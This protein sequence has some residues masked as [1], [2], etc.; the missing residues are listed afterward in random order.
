MHVARRSWGIVAV[1]LFLTIISTATA[2][3]S[4]GTGE[5]NDPYQIATAADLIALGETAEDYDKHFI[6]TADI[7]LDP[8][9]P[10]RKVFDKAV[11]ASDVNNVNWDFDG[12]PFTG[13]FD[14]MGH[15]ISHLTMKGVGYLGLFGQFGEWNGPGCAVR[16]LGVVAVNITGSGNF[17][18]DYV[19]GLVGYNGSGTLAQCYSTGTVS[20]TTENLAVGG[21]VGYNGSGTLAQCYSSVLV[22]GSAYDVG[23]LVGLNG[24]IVT[25]CYSTG[26]VSGTYEVGGLVGANYGTVT[27][28]YSTGAVSSS[29]NSVGGLVGSHS[30]RV[31]HSIWDVE[32]S[33]LSRSGGG[34]GLTTEEMMDSYVIGLKGF[35]NDPNWVLDAGHDYPRLAW[36]GTP[37]TIIPVPDIDWF[38]GH[39]TAEDPYR[40]NTADQF[41]SLGRESILCDRHFVLSADIDLDPNLPGGQVFTQAPIPLFVG[42]LDGCGH[43]ISHLRI[44]GNGYLGVFGCIESGAEVKNLGVVDV[45][46]AGSL[47]FV[48]SLAGYN[49]GGVSQCYSTGVVSGRSYVGGLVGSNWSGTV[50]RCSS[51]GAVNGSDHVGGLVGENR[52]GTITWCYS[53]VE[54]EGNAERRCVGG[55]VGGNSGRLDQCYST[56]VVN[57]SGEAVGGLV[58]YN[59]DS[60]TRCYSTG[61]VSGNEDVG[62]L[63]GNNGYAGSVIHCHSTGTVSGERHVG[64]LVGWNEG[65]VTHCYS[66]GA[67]IGNEDVGGLIGWPY[68]SRCQSMPPTF[69]DVGGLIGWPYSSLVTACFWDTQTSGQTTSAGGTGKTTAEMQRAKMFLDAGWYP[70]GQ[71]AVWTIDEGRDYPRLSW[72]DKPGERIQAICLSD[73]LAGRGTRDDP[74]LIFTPEDLNM[75]GLATCDLDK[76]FRLMADIDLSGF[77]GK[78]SRP[79]FNIIA[80]GEEVGYV[81]YYGYGRSWGSYCQGVPFTGVFDG[82]GHTVLNFTYTCTSTASVYIG[83]FGNVNDPNAQIKDLG[84]IEPNVIRSSVPIEPGGH[85]ACLVGCL[86][87]GTISG[88]YVRGGSVKGNYDYHVGGLVGSNGSCISWSGVKSGDGQVCRGG[89]ILNSYTS[90]SVSG[91]GYVGGL[92]GWNAGPVIRCYSTGAVIGNDGVGGGLIGCPYSSLVT[93]CFWDTQTSGQAEMPWSAGTGKTTAEMQTASTFLGWGCVPEVWT[94]EEG[95]DYPRLAWEGKPGKALPALAKFVAGSGSQGDPYL[96]C[97][98]DDLNTIAVFLSEGDKHFKL[99]ADIDMSGFDGRDGRP[100]FNIIG[101]GYNNAFTGVFDGGGHTISHLT[102]QGDGLLG[103]FGQLGSGGEVKDLVV[104][105]VNIIG[106]GDR[107]GGLVGENLRGS[108][109]RCYITG[110]VSGVYCVGGLVGSNGLYPARGG[111]VTQ[112]YSTVAVSGESNLGGLV[113]DNYE[114]DVTNSYSAGAVTAMRGFVG[115]LVGDNFGG[116]VVQCYSTG[117]VTGGDKVG[118]LVGDSWGSNVTCSFWD[119][120]TSGCATSSGGTGQTTAEMQTAKTF[121]NAGWDFVGETDNGTED[122]WWIVEGKDYPHLWWELNEEDARNP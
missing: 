66:T 75:V 74:Y 6:L 71:P 18:D 85:V 25:Q 59:W 58:G 105:D 21:L 22:S 84:L 92:V 72:E 103:L 94:I 17:Y 93:A 90:V 104:V 51:A 19:G 5:P 116:V 53:T 86:E 57:G 45:N 44:E 7:D 13:V 37:G 76:H 55:L 41:I 110:A 33:G 67:V 98:G 78:D 106:S 28:C 4:G 3:Y 48:G 79:A 9:L 80:P 54:V 8:N 118:G 60:V 46:I 73:V 14:G 29:G 96:I 102:V 36:E 16:N 114:G 50:I 121:L 81:E 42:V 99:T 20:G 65:P 39:G 52:E 30:G 108:V 83:L 113:G 69:L 107:V 47:D 112:C 31:F 10:G 40:V 89:T 26:A 122:I 64:G 56:G 117:P 97:R 70:C 109:S 101:A 82:N 27:Q 111:T 24:G 100:S 62:G 15:T 32:T 88:C 91:I 119:I 63:V 87:Q 77:D 2:K 61:T 11:I 23:G 35:A 95:V 115:G 1:G 68:S 34:V 120:E 38:D 49:S 12:I 43:T